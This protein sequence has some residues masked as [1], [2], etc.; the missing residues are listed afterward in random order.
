MRNLLQQHM[1]E[2]KISFFSGFLPVI[3]VR[4]RTQGSDRGINTCSVV[5][6]RLKELF[7]LLDFLSFVQAPGYFKW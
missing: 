2:T 5:E 3:L 7:I 4:E 6:C 1:I